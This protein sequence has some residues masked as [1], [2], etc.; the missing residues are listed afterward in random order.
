MSFQHLSADERAVLAHLHSTGASQREIARQLGRSSSTISREL[1]RG[2]PTER[3]GYLAERAQDLAASRRASANGLR[4]RM[5]CKELLRHVRAGLK[6]RWS[7]ELIVGRLQLLGSK[8]RVC[9]MTLYRFLKRDREE[10]GKLHKG[11]P[12]RG[13]GRRPNGSKG[14]RR[15]KPGRRPIEDRPAGASNRTR[16]G[17]WE[18]DTV[19]GAGKSAYIVTLVDRKSRFTL[20]GKAKNKSQDVVCEVVKRLLKRLSKVLRRTLT[21]DNGTEFN[22]HRAIEVGTGVDVFFADPYC[23]WQRGT[24]EQT[25]GVMR[26]FLPKGTNF[27]TVS[28]KRLARIE[29]LLNN[30]PRKCLGYRTPAEVI[31]KLPAALRE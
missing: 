11:L 28:S 31:P 18:G 29:D 15:P 9:A 20:L 5:R 23:S 24:N 13:K 25:N 3:C 27:K 16:H 30:R 6:L 1:R 17:H 4:A 2:R 21:L 19:E 26:H 8:I 22:S 7:P 14:R 12:R 10:G